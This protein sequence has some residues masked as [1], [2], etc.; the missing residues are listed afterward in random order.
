[1]SVVRSLTIGGTR[2]TATNFTRW[3]HE[4]GGR[5]SDL[6]RA[7]ATY[8]I[9]VR[10]GIDSREVISTRLDRSEVGARG[11]VTAVV[12]QVTTGVYD[13]AHN[14]YLDII[15]TMVVVTTPQ[16]RTATTWLDQA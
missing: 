12:Y 3:V 11:E 14:G 10:A 8:A 6:A 16:I 7:L 2:V 4:T 15:T 13:D 5:P 9:Q 1:V